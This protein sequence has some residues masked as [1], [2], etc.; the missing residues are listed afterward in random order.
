MLELSNMILA[1]KLQEHQLGELLDRVKLDR[2]ILNS[3]VENL[4][5]DKAF[6][7]A[8]RDDLGNA[9]ISHEHHGNGVTVD[10]L[11]SFVKGLQSRQGHVI[12]STG[13]A[14]IELSQNNVL[15]ALDSKSIFTGQTST[16]PSPKYFGGEHRL[17][18]EGERNNVM[19]AF[20]LHG[21][22][23]E[24]GDAMARILIAL[25]G[26]HIPVQYG[27]IHTILP[28]IGKILQRS[29]EVQLRTNL[30][31]YS[32][33]G[34]LGI[35]L[36]APRDLDMKVILEAICKD[37][38]GLAHQN[39]SAEQFATAKA[40]AAAQFAKR[41]ES[42]LGQVLYVSQQ[43]VIRPNIKTASDF[44]AYLD[45]LP[46]SDLKSVYNYNCVSH[47]FIVNAMLLDDGKGIFTKGLLY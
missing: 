27:S 5:W 18:R 25:L 30:V 41:F 46:P 6:E 37:L 32:N 3:N 13:I 19:L 35:N 44:H 12:A 23:D 1:P 28:G 20:G 36:S 24:Q 34:L 8:Y 42:R 4:L 21:L 15:K 43:A 2:E 31:Q 39:I 29:P 47:C 45:S 14:P 17:E 40:I 22:E 16:P 7:A 11:L 26:P 9:I 33:G 10:S 38:K